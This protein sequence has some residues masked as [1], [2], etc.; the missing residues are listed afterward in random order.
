MNGDKLHTRPAKILKFLPSHFL[1][2]SI[3]PS[4]SWFTLVIFLFFP[5]SPIFP[6][7]AARHIC[8]SALRP[9]LSLWNFNSSLSLNTI[10]SETDRNTL[11]IQSC[12]SKSLL[13]FY[14]ILIYKII[15][16]ILLRLLL[17]GTEL[18]GF[19]I[20]KKK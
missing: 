7:N 11:S 13:Q 19:A 3:F 6:I 10:L 15:Q 17:T 14:K 18:R 1:G 4:E 20:S 8:R 9:H 16:Y 5:K 12:S 2:S